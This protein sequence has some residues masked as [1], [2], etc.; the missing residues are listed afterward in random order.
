MGGETS[1][2]RR[3]V[4]STRKL[5]SWLC[6][7]GLLGF[8]AATAGCGGMAPGD[9]IIYKVSVSKPKESASCYFPLDSLPPNEKSDSETGRSNALVTLTAGLDDAFYLDVDELV[10]GFSSIAGTATDDG[11]AFNRKKVDVEYPEGEDVTK[12][13]IT[14]TTIVDIA[15]T[16]DG[17]AV[18]GTTTWS[19]SVKCTNSG[20]CPPPT[21]TCKITSEFVG[22]E[23]QDIELKHEVK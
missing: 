4:M 15:M 23:L 1:S 3:F 19:H 2:Y 10:E 18:S 9:Y 20:S 17:N 12:T 14:T 6:A 22:S 21:P 16:V 7:L 5:S 11:Y 8:G 13:R